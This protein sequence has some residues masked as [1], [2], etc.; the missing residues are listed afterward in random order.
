MGAEKGIAVDIY[1]VEAEGIISH[2]SRKYIDRDENNYVR[3]VV[4]NHRSQVFCLLG[5]SGL[6]YDVIDALEVRGP[7]HLEQIQV[8]GNSEFLCVDC[9]GDILVT[10]GQEDRSVSLIRGAQF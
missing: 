4:I 10:V 2:L 5:E 9:K 6:V 8:K 1:K 3:R 7:S